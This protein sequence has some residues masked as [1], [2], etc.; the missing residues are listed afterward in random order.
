MKDNR[1]SC[2]FRLPK[3]TIEQINQL[4]TLTGDSKSDVIMNSVFA[5][6]DRINNNAETQKLLNQLKDIQNQLRGLEQLNLD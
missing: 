4:S 2:T 6:Y 3:A 1:I 5:A